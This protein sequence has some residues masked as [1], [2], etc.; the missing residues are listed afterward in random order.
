MGEPGFELVLG[1]AEI[2]HVIIRI[3]YDISQREVVAIQAPKGHAQTFQCV[4]S[5]MLHQI[6]LPAHLIQ[7]NIAAF[8]ARPD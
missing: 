2:Y 3:G 1:P 4:P 8:P 7:R 6:L 5:S